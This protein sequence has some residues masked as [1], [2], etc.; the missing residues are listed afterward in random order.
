MALPAHPAAPAAGLR[1]RRASPLSQLRAQGLL[2]A[3]RPRPLPRRAAL[4]A[5]A[6]GGSGAGAPASAASAPAAGFRGT[7][8]VVGAGPAG[9]T[10]AMFLADAGFRVHVL[11]R[12][13]HPGRV[14]ADRRRTYLIGLGERGLRALDA[15]GLSVPL[16]VGRPMRGSVY[17]YKS[18]QRV[19]DPFTPDTRIG[20][21]WGAARGACGSA[22]AAARPPRAHRAAAGAAAAAAAPRAVGVDRQ[23]LAAFLVAAAA[24]RHP[25]AVSFHWGAA[26]DAIDLCARTLTWTR[27]GAPDGAEQQQQQ[28]QQ[29]GQQ[30]SAAVDDGGGGGGDGGT[31][32]YDLLVGADG[33]GS[34]VRGAML[35]ALPGMSVT[36]LRSPVAELEY[37]AFHGL[38]WNDD[39]AALLP[40]YAPP[41]PPR[42]QE[43]ADTAAA[44]AGPAN[45]CGGADPG[46]TFFAFNNPQPG[47]PS[48][49]SI[50]LYLNA[51]G[52]WS[53][54]VYQPPGRYAAMAGDAAAHEAA[55]REFTPPGFPEAWVPAMARQM[56][57]IGPSRINPMQLVSQLAA[58]QLGV[59]LLGDA[60]HNV[61][62]QMGQGCNSALEDAALLGDA[63]R[64][65][66]YDTAAALESFQ[67]RRMPQ[68][69]ALQ[70]MEEENSWV[71]RPADL[72]RDPPAKTLARVAWVS[73]FCLL[74]LARLVP[75]LRRAV[76]ASLFQTIMSTTVG[77]DRLHA[78]IRAAPAALAALVWALVSAGGWLAARAWALAAA[79]LA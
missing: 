37:K 25:D 55:V 61:T 75:G 56:A 62:P 14:E 1:G 34:A 44:A 46:M 70:R 64:R 20:A 16:D 49:G 11:E 41:P 27:G 57:S 52:T 60:G 26:P 12:R 51:A 6:E 73:F 39:I 2:A 28:Q 24:A 43:G 63:L 45:A 54:T 3:A 76:H 19:E 7:A 59:V 17:A 48:P 71:R 67:R 32:A 8:V 13:G 72:L 42:G 40:R 36:R 29:Q 78:A 33:A 31:L 69:H 38:P 23:G 21:A 5:R 15:L 22:R 65:A 50:T 30:D 74:P 79:A 4:P 68:V 35:G 9:A 77:Y 53:G 47:R 66:D 18:G 58:P 10:A